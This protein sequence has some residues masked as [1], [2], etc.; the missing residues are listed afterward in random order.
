MRFTNAS[1]R[2]PSLTRVGPSVPVRIARVILE[3][4][5]VDVRI[6]GLVIS[7]SPRADLANSRCARGPILEVMAVGY[8]CR[9]A[10]TVA[11]PE[12]LFAGIGHEHDL[13]VEDV[14]KLVL[15]RVP[16]PLARPR[17]RW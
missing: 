12:K 4:M 15:H 7:Q 14:H 3:R 8:A 17:A 9:E 10:R 16:V 13:A 11:G 1:R 2:G 5:Q 6:E